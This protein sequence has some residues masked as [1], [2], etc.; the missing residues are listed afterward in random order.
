MRFLLLASCLIL[1]ACNQPEGKG[2]PPVR[3]YPD[4]YQERA[5]D[6][7]AYLPADSPIRRMMDD[8]KK[9]RDEARKCQ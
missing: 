3:V 2:C 7:L 5:A 6:D 8:Y 4:A 1:A 9:M